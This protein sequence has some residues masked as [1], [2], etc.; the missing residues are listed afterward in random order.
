M[1]GFIECDLETEFEDF[2]TFTNAQRY[3]SVIFSTMQEI[4]RRLKYTDINEKESLQLES[5]REFI[6]EELDGIKYE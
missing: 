6:L 3:K 2:I 5:L 4:R 1:K